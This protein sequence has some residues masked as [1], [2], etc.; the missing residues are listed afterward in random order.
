MGLLGPEYPFFNPP[1]W[2][3]IASIA[4][5][6]PVVRLCLL[7]EAERRPKASGIAR[8]ISLPFL[9]FRL[10]LELFSC[11]TRVDQRRLRPRGKLA[12]RDSLLATSLN[13]V[14][15]LTCN[16]GPLFRIGDCCQ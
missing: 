14:V 6:L 1:E 12:F 11:H 5:K 15:Y 10:E 7:L 2:V 8:A 9:A 16:S 13:N 3:E 4:A